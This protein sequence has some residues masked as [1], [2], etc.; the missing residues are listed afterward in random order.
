M[1]EP[2]LLKDILRRFPLVPV[3]SICRWSFGLDTE[4]PENDRDVYE[5]GVVCDMSPDTYPDSFDVREQDK[6]GDL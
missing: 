6:P 4:R 2:H 5:Q 3:Q 1:P